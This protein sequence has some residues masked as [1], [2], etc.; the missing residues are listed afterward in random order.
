MKSAKTLLAE[1][2]TDEIDESEEPKEMTPIRG[3]KLLKE[4]KI[5]G[6]AR[7]LFDRTETSDRPVNIYKERI[8]DADS[9]K[10]GFFIWWTTEDSH[11]L[12]RQPLVKMNKKTSDER[13]IGYEF[14]IPHSQKIIDEL[15]SKAYS[16]TQFIHKDG[17]SR[18][19]VKPEMF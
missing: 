1:E 13:V 10:T 4:K 3:G 2:Q 12:G 9:G 11:T 17:N 5:I 15:I 8:T 6:A 7:V 16:K 18:I 14:T 19:S